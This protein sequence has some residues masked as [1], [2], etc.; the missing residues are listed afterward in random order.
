MHVH[1]DIEMAAE[2]STDI[3][4]DSVGLGESTN[5]QFSAVSTSTTFNSTIQTFDNYHY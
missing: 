4:A 2:R 1:S 3:F 5:H